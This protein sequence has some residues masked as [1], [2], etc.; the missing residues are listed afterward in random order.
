[1]TD[2]AIKIG[3]VI[4][5][6]EEVV[7]DGCGNAL[8]ANS[9]NWKDH[10]QAV[11]GLA[12]ERLT[13]ERFGPSYQLRENAHVE[14]VEFFCHHCRAL[15]SVEIYTDGEPYRWDYQSLAVAR[16]RGYD[17]VREFRDAPEDWVSF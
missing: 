12:S 16:D 2:E 13:A 4:W 8:C 1:M 5:R 14:V 10:V 3:K 6:D 7:C 17:P 15:L 11:R 9:E